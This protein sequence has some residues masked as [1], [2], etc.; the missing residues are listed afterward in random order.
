M[1]DHELVELNQRL[2]E[3][4]KSALVQAKADIEVAQT[5]RDRWMLRTMAAER[6]YHTWKD[7]VILGVLMAFGMGLMFGIWA[8]GEI[9]RRQEALRLHGANT[10]YPEH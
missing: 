3:K 7:R 5:E 2:N 4:L 1:N 9:S 10:S 6:G 8:Q